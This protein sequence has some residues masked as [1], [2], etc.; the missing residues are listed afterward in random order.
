MQRLETSNPGP[1]QKG[2]DVKE[3]DFIYHESR[4]P[5]RHFRGTKSQWIEE[6]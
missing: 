6:D 5:Y 1:G 4:L 3:G 2:N